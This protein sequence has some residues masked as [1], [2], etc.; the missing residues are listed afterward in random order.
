MGNA[1]ITGAAIR[2]RGIVQGVGFRPLVY[3]RALSFNLKGFIQN[4]DTGVLVK[5]DGTEKAIKSFYDDIL[6][7]PPVLAQ[8][9]SSSIDLGDSHGFENFIIIRSEEEGR[10]FTPISPDV[11][12]CGAC[13]KEILD[14]ADRR[15]RYAFTNCT[16]CGPRF[17]IIRTIPYDRKY[18][19]MSVFPM[20]SRCNAE[21][22][23]PLDRRYHAQ[24]NACPD[25]GPELKLL[26]QDGTLV[27]GDPVT[28]SVK[29]LGEGKIIA[30][31]G[32]GGYHLAVSPRKNEWVER[33]RKRKRRPGK[34]FAL[35]VRNVDVARKY[36]TIGQEEEKLLLSSERPIVLLEKDPDG[37]FLSHET[38]PDTA[39]VG[40]MLPYTPLHHILMEEGP[41]I[42]IM[43][44]ANM[45]EEPLSYQDADASQSLGG[46]ADGFLTHNREIQRPCDDSV[47]GVVEGRVVPIRRSRGYVPRMVDANFPDRQILAAGASEKNTF[48]IF[49][50]G[51]AFMS[52]HIGD[53]NNVKSIDAYTN[54]IR[55]FLDMFR[56][57]PEA[58]VCDLHPDYESTRYA[59]KI[60]GV[61]GVPLFRV[62]HHHAHI[63]AV[64]GEKGVSQKVIGVAFDGTGYGNDETVWG[65]EFFIADGQ[66]YERAGHYAPV[67]MPGGEKAILETDRMAVAHLI[68]SYG[69]SSEIPKFRFVKEIGQRRL[70]LLEELI[71][72]GVNTPL[73]SSCGRLFDAVSALLG[74]CVK[75][76]YD[77]QGAILLETEAHGL[78]DLGEP[79]PYSMAPGLVLHFEPMIRSIVRDVVNEVSSKNIARRFHI[80]VI[81]S[82]VEVCKKIR[83]KTGIELVALAGGVFQNRIVLK[84]FIRLLERNGFSVLINSLVPPNDG[85]ISFGQG[86][87]ALKLME[88][89]SE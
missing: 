60:A 3:R 81:L 58:V 71:G 17:T 57:H 42:L 74:L 2:F 24:P 1:G 20:C 43:T 48:C 11:A 68:S 30:V 13:R 41:E 29:L 82:G 54:G 18:T 87:A 36:C 70:H 56:V 34:P 88:G 23:D 25:C 31:K 47:I 12:T 89:G 62:Q 37:S 67:Q 39:L 78:E 84:H 6:T 40:L 32:L 14:P 9:H 4:T 16:D 51:K 61:W 8:I 38:A 86:V 63:A 15:Y 85:G 64:L 33:L 66:T 44:S 75:P 10:G 49:K 59:E 80:T 7:N 76:L 72:A 27:D 77:A 83:E 79:Y 22:S 19:T 53:L 28:G 21:Y 26:D 65:G 55:D 73:T 5:V 45:T 69:S 50:D 35:M 52:H 46:I